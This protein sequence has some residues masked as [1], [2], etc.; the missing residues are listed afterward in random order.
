MKLRGAILLG[1]KIAFVAATSGLVLLLSFYLSVRSLIFGNEVKVPD[2]SRTPVAEARGRLEAAGLTLE[3]AGERFDPGAPEGAII[4]QTPPAGAAIKTNRKVKVV[5]SRGTEVLDIPDLTGTS[6]RRAL[7]EI[8][9]LGLQLGE[10]AR[11]TAA[12]RSPDQ[13]IAQDPRPGT[14]IF[15]G[16]KISLLVSRGSR[17]PVWVMPDLGGQPLAGA[18]R[19]LAD[20]GLR[21]GHTRVQPSPSPA[22]I[23]VGQF[24][25]PGYPVS[26]RDPITLVVSGEPVV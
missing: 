21:V 2:L 16:D 4:S 12:A 18:R 24:P 26:R 1:L 25:Q 15:R 14:E 9:R 20:H 23:V 22:G 17:E 19:L 10:V 11:V 8:D 6:E 7:L 5:V 13:V 3:V